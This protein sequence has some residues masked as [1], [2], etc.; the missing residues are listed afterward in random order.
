MCSRFPVV[1][2]QYCQVGVSSYIFGIL[3]LSPFIIMCILGS[4]YV[5]VEKL[6]TTTGTPIQWA[7]LLSTVLW[8]SSG[9]DDVGQVWIPPPPNLLLINLQLAGEIKEPAK[10]FPRA[11]ISTMFLVIIMYL[12]PLGVGKYRTVSLSYLN[13]LQ[14]Y[15]SIQIQLTGLMDILA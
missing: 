8:T 14:A 5:T 13:L 10:N 3:V 9:W 7:P 6:T 15:Q 2:L 1:D 4:K 12:L 11:M